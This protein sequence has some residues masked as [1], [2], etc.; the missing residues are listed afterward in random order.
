[1]P[2]YPWSSGSNHNNLQLAMLI[3]TTAPLSPVSSPHGTAAHL[4][5]RGPRVSCMQPRTAFFLCQATG[6]IAL[7][8]LSTLFPG[9]PPFRIIRLNSA[10]SPSRP[11]ARPA[12]H[13]ARPR[14]PASAHVARPA[15]RRVHPLARPAH[16]LEGSRT[17]C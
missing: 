13:V 10:A 14:D 6:T 12:A 3:H 5:P 11:S 4:P 15:P 2:F 9:P 16:R 8:S 17:S 7:P 1:M